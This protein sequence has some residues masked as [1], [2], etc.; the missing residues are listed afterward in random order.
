MIDFENIDNKLQIIVHENQS[1]KQL[2]G[3]FKKCRNVLL[4]GHGGN[5][6]VT[7]HLSIDMSRLTD[8]MCFAPGSG[9]VVTSIITDFS[10][11]QWLVN[12]T[13][14]MTRGLN[15]EDT[16]VIALSCSTG[17]AS[18]NAILRAL[19]HC[20]DNIG[21]ESFL[22]TAQP[23]P[24]ISSN[25]NTI[26][27][28]CI[29]YHTAEVLSMMLLYQLIWSHSD[30]ACPPKIPIR[31]RGCSTCDYGSLDHS[32][33]DPIPQQINPSDQLDLL[34]ISSHLDNTP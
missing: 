12:W 31:D 22:I 16:I 30:G 14:I 10:F 3:S 18:S 6:G 9:I 25:V 7:D 21:I 1:W 34:R 23:K 26:V 8:K 17:S 29:Y 11:D 20:T 13:D 33:C 2:E 24:D 4:F 27:T 15:A 28:D 5:L 32:F 19:T